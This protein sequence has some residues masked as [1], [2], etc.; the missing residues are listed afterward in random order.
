MLRVL[1]G[2]GGMAVTRMTEA[3]KTAD[4]G[5]DC[6]LHRARVTATSD[7]WNPIARAWRTTQTPILI[8]F[9]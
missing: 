6:A 4:G 9:S 5:K 8:N 1:L 3:F 7:S 2:L